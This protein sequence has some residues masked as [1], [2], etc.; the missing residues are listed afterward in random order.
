MVFLMN[1][2]EQFSSTDDDPAVR[3]PETLREMLLANFKP[4]PAIP[5]LLVFVL[6][7]VFSAMF[8]NPA[9]FMKGTGTVIS[10]TESGM[11]A[12]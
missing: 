11:P 12:P 5:A 6:C 3:A 8:H 9:G 2:K 10:T 7:I 4:Q 1:E